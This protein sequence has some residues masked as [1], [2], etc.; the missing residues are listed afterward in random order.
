MLELIPGVL[1]LGLGFILLFARSVMRPGTDTH[2]MYMLRAATA[3]RPFPAVGSVVGLSMLF[4]ASSAFASEKDLVLPDL[5]SAHFLG[6]P[7]NVLIM[8]GFLFC[9]I[10]LA[11]GLVIY[12]ELKNLP[13]HR[14]M[15]EISELIYET[16]KT[17]LIT[18]GKFI[19]MLEVLIGTIMVIYFGVLERNP[20]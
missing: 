5:S 14:S 12:N 15:G 6:L 20:A 1:I 4:A 7:G 13:V 16:C 2:S 17:Y 8:V 9:F 10:V 18:Q 19:L 11:F 3:G